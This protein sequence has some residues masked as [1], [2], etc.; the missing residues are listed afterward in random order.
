MTN[1]TRFFIFTLLLLPGPNI[2]LVYHRGRQTFL[3]KLKSHFDVLGSSAKPFCHLKPVPTTR[4][5][6][7]G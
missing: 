1:T 6:K 7:V 5:I 2:T 3:L 4:V